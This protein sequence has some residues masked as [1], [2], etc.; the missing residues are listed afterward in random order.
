L[1]S[2]LMIASALREVNFRSLKG[3]SRML[4]CTCLSIV[5][6]SATLWLERDSVGGVLGVLFVGGFLFAALHKMKMFNERG[7]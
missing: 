2:G 1:V 4:C 7:S 3:I 6:G 5:V